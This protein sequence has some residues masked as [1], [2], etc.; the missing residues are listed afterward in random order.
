MIRSGKA[1]KKLRIGLMA[2]LLGV[3]GIVTTAVSVDDGTEQFVRDPALLEAARS[4][5]ELA[6]V[7]RDNPLQRLFTPVHS[8][9]SIRVL[10][11]HCQG[12]IPGRG[13][14]ARDAVARVRFYSL[15][16]IPVADVYVTCGGHSAQNRRPPEW[17]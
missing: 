17:F 6:W 16:V 14:P 8:V 11:G 7:H 4:A 10:P 2:M 5:Y 13:S 3:L 9:H 1:M 15:F 12:A